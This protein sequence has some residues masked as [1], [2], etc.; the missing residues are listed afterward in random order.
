M[1]NSRPQSEVYREAAMRRGPIGEPLR[2]K[3]ERMSFPDP[4]SGCWLWTGCVTP[5]GYGYVGPKVSS[6]SRFAHRISWEAANG[7]VPD[8]MF[9]L[10][11]CD[12]PPCVNP[13]HLFLGTARDNTEDMV[14]KGRMKAVWK[15][16]YPEKWAEHMRK[17]H[18][19]T[20][21]RMRAKYAKR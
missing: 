8:G 9:V 12:N 19:A 1:N 18:Q 13:A 10:H 6:G 16:K 11:R 20:G 7:P 3:I 15:D 4:N 5:K 2:D 14:R 21:E 17:L